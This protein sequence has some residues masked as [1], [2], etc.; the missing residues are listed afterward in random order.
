MPVRDQ[1]CY[2]ISW[3][4]NHCAHF[5]PRAF[6]FKCHKKLMEINLLATHKNLIG[7]WLVNYMFRL[8]E[9]NNTFQC[10]SADKLFLLIVFSNKVMLC[11]KEAK[12]ILYKR[13][14]IVVEGN[15]FHISYFL[16]YRW[17][18][19]TNENIIRK[20]VTFMSVQNS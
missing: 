9:N 10:K 5:W 16:K 1:G 2:R 13:H 17:K 6:W 7:N 20:Y 4:L 18:E 14:L 12:T 8:C 19:Q 3:I 11:L 15:L